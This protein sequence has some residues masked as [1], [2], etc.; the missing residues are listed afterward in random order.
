MILKLYRIILFVSTVHLLGF[1]VTLCF[2]LY[3]PHISPFPILY[4]SFFPPY[5]LGG[6]SQRGRNKH[7][8]VAALRR[9]WLRPA[10]PVGSQ[11][12]YPFLS[13]SSSA[14]SSS[15]PAEAQRASRSFSPPRRVA[16]NCGLCEPQEQSTFTAPILSGSAYRPSPEALRAWATRPATLKG[17]ISQTPFSAPI[18]SRFVLGAPP[19]APLMRRCARGRR[20][21]ESRYSLSD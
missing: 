10:R 16:A 2:S 20:F 21:Y 8:D 6:R 11:K 4:F 12:H 17:R 19:P 7:R 15:P 18:L 3:L 9:G 5:D 13:N 1:L 14:Y